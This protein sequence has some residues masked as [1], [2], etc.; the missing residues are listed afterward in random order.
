MLLAA[1]QAAPGGS[2]KAEP[3][4]DVKHTFQVKMQSLEAKDTSADLKG[5]QALAKQTGGLYFDYKNMNRLEEL[6]AAIPDDPQ[7]LSQA[8]PL[9]LWD[10]VPFLML[11]L[12]LICAEW[13]LRKL[14][15]LL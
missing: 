6:I 3:L 4:F 8:V 11:F 9:D 7:V 5:M 15:G 2:T 13:S 10:G 12:V 14:W 1:R